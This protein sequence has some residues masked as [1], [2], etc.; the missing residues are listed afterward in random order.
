MCIEPFP[1]ESQSWD[2]LHSRQFG[3]R[4]GLG[5]LLH[6]IQYRNVGMIN[7]RHMV[8]I[9]SIE[10][11]KVLDV[12]IVRFESRGHLVVDGPFEGVEGRWTTIELGWLSGL[13]T[14]ALWPSWPRIQR[15]WTEYRVACGHVERRG[16]RLRSRLELW[17]EKLSDRLL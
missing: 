10:N 11:I 7:A 1:V 4:D 14:H 17:E 16:R 5:G 15:D 8:T 9:P 6:K 12:P 2:R 3:I 13:N